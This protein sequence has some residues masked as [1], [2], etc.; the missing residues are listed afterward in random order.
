M[1]VNT[2]GH[3]Q[4][5]SKRSARLRSLWQ[6]RRGAA[7]SMRSTPD[8]PGDAS[9]LIMALVAALTVA[10][11]LA[12]SMELAPLFNSMANCAAAVVNCTPS[13]F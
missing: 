6:D 13:A 8:R 7:P 1:L 5:D 10:G 9:A 3:G 4:R 11:I 2:M 12:V